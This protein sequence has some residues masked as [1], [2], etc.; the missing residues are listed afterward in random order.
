[1]LIKGD[2]AQLEW[3][4]YLEL[5][6][7]PV[8][9][10]EVCEGLD[11]HTNNQQY[12]NLPSRLVSKVF[13]FRY[14]YRG[15]AFAYSRD[16][17]FSHVSSDISFWQR[18]IDAANAKYNVLYQYQ[19]SVLEK[20]RR[21]EV[22]ILPSGR[23]FLFDISQDK[24]GKYYWDEKKITNYINQG[25]GADIMLCARLI[26][27]IRLKKYFKNQKALLINTVHDDVVLDV[28]N[29]PE[30]LYNISI[31]VEECFSKVPEFFTK[32]FDKEFVV[33]IAG[34]VKFGHNRNEMTKFDRNLGKDQFRC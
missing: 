30:L 28:D 6:R 29:D 3:R 4:S 10:Q 14:I 31:E 17:E 15:S 7:D 23:E 1:M 22:V 24:K 26:L 9:L 5:S 25:F 34:E 21:R 33:P 13:L 2:A 12:F 18:V 11:I 8:G 16:I 32:Y 19:E 20:A 27:R